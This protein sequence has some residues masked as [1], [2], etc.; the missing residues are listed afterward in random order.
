MAGTTWPSLVAGRKAKAS[1]VEAKFDWLEGSLVPQNSGSTTDLSYDLGTS[2]ARWRGLWVGGINPTTTAGG[3]AVGTTTVANASTGLELAGTTKAVL[4]SRMTTA[5]RTALTALSGMMVYD[6]DIGAFYIYENGAWQTMGGKIGLIAKV[7]THSDNAGNT[8]TA[9]S[10][11][12]SGR[13]HSILLGNGASNLSA[14][15]IAVVL[16]SVS[17]ADIVAA[18]TTAAYAAVRPNVGPSN[19]G[20]FWGT[21]VTAADITSTVAGIMNPITDLYFKSQAKVYLW[22]AGAQTGTVSILYESA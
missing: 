20:P 13:I 11:T 4:L 2:T 22:G 21:S 6:S 18:T 17:V 1:E 15:H 16:D 8:V 9:L 10:I 19:T 12:G 14:S 5:Q 3:V 7:I